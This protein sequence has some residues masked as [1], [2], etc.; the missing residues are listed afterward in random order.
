[1]E[2]SAL[3]RYLRESRETKEITLDEAVSALRIRRPFL[4][5]FERGEFEGIDSPVQLRG[6]LRNY[7]RHLGLDEE[8]VLQYYEQ[9]QDSNRRKRRFGRKVQDDPAP[10]APATVTDTQPTPPPTRD[11]RRKK[12]QSLNLLDVLRAIMMILVS[13]AAVMVIGFVAYDTIFQEASSE[14]EAAMTTPPA[15]GETA[16]ATATYTA[17]WTPRPT[18]TDIPDVF[19]ADI[20]GVQVDV[21]ILQRTWL[22]VDVDG[23]TVFT[24]IQ[25][26][27]ERNMYTGANRIAVTASN[28]AGLSVIFNEEPQPPFGERGQQVEI[29]FTPD[30]IGMTRVNA[31]DPTA[32]PTTTPVPTDTPIPV[33]QAPSATT[34]TAPARPTPVSGAS[35]D[36]PPMTTVLV[37]SPTPLFGGD[38]APTSVADDRTRPTVIVT[39]AQTVASPTVPAVTATATTAALVPPRTPPA[40][41]TATKAGGI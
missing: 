30:G 12:R 39:V 26:P 16:T 29:D 22:Q 23:E 2:P 14:L 41:P 20:T 8:R 32:T 15:A 27:G 21:E 38:T 10:V 3:G 6:M 1:M 25:Q 40:N 4:E 31:G 17:S 5:A 9:S 19:G 11:Q 28:A 13:V 36:E 7:A 33:E 35:A 34:T 24:G 18:N 37:A